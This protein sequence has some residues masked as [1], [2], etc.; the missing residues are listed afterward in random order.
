MKKSRKKSKANSE[1]QKKSANSVNPKNEKNKPAEEAAVTEAVSEAAAP[2]SEKETAPVEAAVPAAVEAPA[3]EPVPN[4]EEATAEEP[5]PNPEE[6]TAE[7]PAPEPEEA[8]TEKPATEP[9]EAPTE[10][11]TTESEE[12]P[13]EEPATEP[14]EAPT[15]EP[16]SEPEEA[17]AEEPATEPEETP[18]EEPASEPEEAPAEELTTE[19]EEAPA[20]E[21][22][23]EPEEA[24]TEELTTEP[25][26]APTEELT[27]EPEEAPAEE[28][29]AEAEE[30]PADET[31]RPMFGAADEQDGEE[32]VLSFDYSDNAE[33]EEAVIDPDV[34]IDPAIEIRAD[35][36]ASANFALQQNG[37]DIVKS[38]IIKNGRD[39]AVR[40][41]DLLITSADELCH[42]FMTHIDYISPASEFEIR[43]PALKLSAE[44]L[45]SVTEAVRGEIL[46]EL[47]QE[48]H[49]LSRFRTELEVLAYDECTGFGV[50]PELLCSFITPNHPD[51]VNI[52]TRASQLLEKWTEDPSFTAYQSCDPNRVLKQAAAVYG[53][54]EEQ[55]IVYSE[56]PP[57]FEQ[58]GQRIRLCDAVLSQKLGNCISK[59][60]G[61][62]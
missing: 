25:E 4:P 42:P 14:E 33:E 21:L 55:N 30:A 47:T 17:P 12:A 24:P 52:I 3:E 5:V 61:C 22:T 62:G 13:T 23:T 35:I 37:L 51:I 8:P 31:A 26:E 9:E 39:E 16:A 6:A 15:E 49:A 2:E 57:S 59:E 1:K 60:K 45:V 10:E 40:D 11:L 29:A 32:P 34:F 50:Y 18:T 56:A 43:R 20:E 58:S 54:I 48:G 28:S 46:F 27:T 41:V 44:K 38:I 7:E 36:I 53:A 19:P